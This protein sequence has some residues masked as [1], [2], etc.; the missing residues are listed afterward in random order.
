MPQAPRPSAPRPPLA[1]REGEASGPLGRREWG[2]GQPA[3]NPQTPPKARRPSRRATR[4]QHRRTPKRANRKKEQLVG[5]NRLLQSRKR[6]APT[7]CRE[8]M[9][10]ETPVS[11]QS[12]PETPD[13][14]QNPPPTRSPPPLPPP[15]KN[16][17]PRSTEETAAAPVPAGS[18]AP[19][20]A[21]PPTTPKSPGPAR[22]P[23][24]P[25]AAPLSSTRASP[26]W[27]LGGRLGKT[28]EMPGQTK[29]RLTRKKCGKPQGPKKNQ[30]VF[31]T[32]IFKKNTSIK[33]RG[34]QPLKQNTLFFDGAA[35]QPNP[36]SATTPKVTKQALKGCPPPGSGTLPFS[37]PTQKRQFASHLQSKKEVKRTGF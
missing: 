36:K 27:R 22:L 6:Q 24:N 13:T 2:A 33:T 11:S 31:D 34:P 37:P 23:P 28:R 18:K 19:R 32:P 26:V 16:T 7:R 17:R 35:P 20:A 3:D 1:V 29:R 4:R 25:K 30:V 9:R 14:S 21:P 8:A 5:K 12:P 10:V 15:E